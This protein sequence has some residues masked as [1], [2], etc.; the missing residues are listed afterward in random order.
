MK[1][2][3]GPQEGLVPASYVEAQAAASA[4]HSDIERPASTYSASSVSLAGSIA[5]SITGGKKKGPVVAPKRGAKKLQY[6]EVL[7]EYTA[8]S[9][10]EH[11]ILEGER[12]VLIKKE[13]GDGWSDVEKNGTVRSVPANYIQ[14]V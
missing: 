1:V 7:Y 13:A 10:Q 12:L 8:R 9:E 2:R 11:S 5:G 4:A 3:S 14:E 6:V